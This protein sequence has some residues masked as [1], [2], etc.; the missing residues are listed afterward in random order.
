MRT[1]E[2]IFSQLM[3]NDTYTRKV[4]PYIKEE[5]FNTQEDKNFFKIYSRYFSKYGVIP[6]KHA[7]LV[8]FE[9][10]KSA[11]DVYNGLV[12]LVGVTTEIVDSPEYIVD[13]TE[14]F[15]KERALYNA[16]K[17]SVLI[18]DG[19]SQGKNQKTPDAIPSILQEALA[20]AFSPDVGH[21]FFDEADARYEYYHLSENRIPLGSK[22]FNS[23]TRGGFPRKTLNVLLA[24]PHGG[25]TLTMCNFAEGAL[26]AGF[27]VLYITMEMAEFE[28]GRRFDVNYLDV[29][30]DELM[31]LPKN[32][33]TS[34]M[35]KIRKESRGSLVIK[36][37]PTGA[38]HAG[39][40]RAYINELKLKKQF[41]PDMIVVDYMG[42]CAS[43]KYKTSSGANSYTIQKSVGEELRA[44]A[45]DLD[46][47]VVTATQT[48]R[49]GVGNSDVDIT[50]TSESFG[51][52]AIAD[53]FAAI[54]TSDELKQQQQTMFK[55]LKNRYKSLDEPNK[56]L[57]GVDVSKMRMFDLDNA[58]SI[59]SGPKSKLN[60]TPAANVDL[61]HV[62]KSTHASFD[63]FNFDS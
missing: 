60:T 18:A 3:Q 2:L 38:A 61:G 9:K 28:I 21:E 17:E 29:D 15:C 19:Q 23:I 12:D 46:A 20:I 56:F 49:S 14:A 37:F 27:N 7:M 32:T 1:E 45:I 33:F 48:N 40:F 41:V 47:A 6:S 51:I 63:D 4:L 16:L 59:P 22:T 13:T 55:Q 44:L 62:I 11:P 30:F 24:P 36:Q 5:Y 35:D 8:E 50:A 25:K 34:R 54:I 26:S 10:L 39:H 43:E 53:W 57:M 42:I 52:P 58:G 31:L